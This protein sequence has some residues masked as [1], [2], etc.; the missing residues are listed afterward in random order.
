MG[1]H[2]GQE[3]LHASGSTSFADLYDKF[4]LMD[5]EKYVSQSP[6]YEGNEDV[7]SLPPNAD[8]GPEEPAENSMMFQNGLTVARW[9]EA[10]LDQEDRYQETPIYQPDQVKIAFFWGH[11]ANSISEMGQ[12]KE[13]MENLDLLVVVDVFPSVASVLPDFEEGP[14]ILL[15]PA[16][17]QY[18]HY[19]SLT[20]T[21]RSVQWSE[22]VAKPAH[23]SKPDLQIMQELA[24]ALGFGEHFDWGA[25]PELYNGKSTYENVIREFNLG[26]NTIGYRQ[27]PERLQ[28]HLEYDYAFSNEDLKGAEGTPVAG[29]YW[30]LPWPCWGEDH[31][32]TPIIW[33]DDLDPNDGGQDFRARWGVQAPTPEEWDEMPTDDDYP[34]QETVNSDRYDSQ[35]EAL[36]LLRAPYQPEW[37]DSNDT[38]ADGQIHGVPEYPGWKTTPPQ[39]LLDPTQD[40]Q[41]DELTIPQQHALDNQRSVYTAAQALANP[42]TGSPEFDA[43][44]EDKI[45]GGVDPSFYE[46]YDFAQPDA[47]TGRG[48]ARAVVWSFLDKVPVHRE[49]IESPRPDLVEEWPANG[50]Q[51]NFYRLDQNNAVEQQRANDIIHEED[52]GPDLDT[53]MTTGRQVEHQGGGSETRSNIH[54]ADLQPH[55]YAEITPN[56]A[57]ELGVDGGDLIVVS[58]TDRGSVLVKARVT[59]RPADGEVFLPF[60]WGGVFKGKSLEDKYPDGHVPYA[61]GDSVNAITS[62]GYDVETQMQETKVSMVAV[63]PATEELLEELNMD[64][65]IEFPQDRDDIGTQKSFDVR[66]GETVQ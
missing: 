31:P 66:D 43:Y 20:N 29:E 37:A 4:E 11:S 48:R 1:R 3:P 52:S 19:R 25:G 24:D 54:T 40:V 7:D 33:N 5:P 22:P 44:L 34:F 47:P 63:R 26:T 49:P 61:I 45:A 15:L 17:S 51:Q 2:L 55:M 39:S 50:Q 6:V 18:E 56:R 21:N 59:D 36:N 30:M 38:A 10:A 28:Q 60:H 64:V 53:I 62:K 41:P 42:E 14:E 58:S 65:D 9:F 35:E 32:G 57:E 8:H 13:G 12:M 46:Q 16:S 27:T 23:N